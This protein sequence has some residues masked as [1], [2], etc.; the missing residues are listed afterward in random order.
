[1]P[2]NEEAP[3]SDL[4]TDASALAA[5]RYIKPRPEEPQPGPDKL[6]GVSPRFGESITL[7]ARF[8][9]LTHPEIY[10][11]WDEPVYADDGTHL[12]SKVQ[13]IRAAAAIARICESHQ[14]RNQTVYPGTSFEALRDFMTIHW[15]RLVT[16]FP[17]N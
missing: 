16:L 7:Y 12:G 15:A 8:V 6:P 11:E 14:Q 17:E 2:E 10:V 9:D 4:M 5:P 3:Q 1:M 13:T